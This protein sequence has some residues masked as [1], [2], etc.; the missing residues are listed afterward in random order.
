V[1]LFLLLVRAPYAGEACLP[2]EGPYGETGRFCVEPPTFFLQAVR[3]STLM[4][5]RGATAKCSLALGVAV[6]FP[7]PSE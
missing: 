7:G 6:S 4:P 2:S 3:P 5:R 1:L